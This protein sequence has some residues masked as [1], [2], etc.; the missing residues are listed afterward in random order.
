MDELYDT[1]DFLFTCFLSFGLPSPSRC[2]EREIYCAEALIFLYSTISMKSKYRLRV[3]SKKNKTN[4]TNYKNNHPFA[5][6]DVFFL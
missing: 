5:V 1:Y 3:S 4:K 2:M 6:I